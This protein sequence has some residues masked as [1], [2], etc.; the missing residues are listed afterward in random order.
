M[1]RRRILQI[2]L[3]AT[4]VVML[5]GV[6]LIHLVRSDSRDPD[7]IRI[8]LGEETAE[9]IRFDGLALVPGDSREYK[10]ELTG[11]RAVQYSLRID[12]AE[13]GESPLKN[14]A[15]VRI[16]SGDEVLCDELLATAF[17]QEELV[18]PVDINKEINTEL[19]FVYYLPL[20]VGNEAKNAVADFD[21]LLTANKE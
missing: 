6:L 5:V 20:D 7:V 4:G 3:I 17:E 9:T 10:V 21:L 11:K 15:Y 13:T 12:F 16:L 14:F 1:S 8:R 2:I 19:T 18:L